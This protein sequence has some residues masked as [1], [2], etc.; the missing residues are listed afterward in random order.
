MEKVGTWLED[1]YPQGGQNKGLK[2]SEVQGSEFAKMP[3]NK[4]ES[5]NSRKVFHAPENVKKE[6][7]V[8]KIIESG[9]VIN[10]FLLPIP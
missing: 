4:H 9:E 2:M 6:E 8:N 7:I 1:H 10:N 5:T 3:V